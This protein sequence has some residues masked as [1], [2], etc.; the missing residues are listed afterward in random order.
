MEIQVCPSFE[1]DYLPGWRHARTFDKLWSTSDGKYHDYF[2]FYPIDTDITGYLSSTS[3]TE[4]D[5]SLWGIGVDSTTT[6]GS[7]MTWSLNEVGTLNQNDRY[8]TNPSGKLQ[9]TGTQ[10]SYLWYFML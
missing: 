3:S 1:C 5:L 9:T 10:N 8:W 4:F 2:Q 6:Y 7:S